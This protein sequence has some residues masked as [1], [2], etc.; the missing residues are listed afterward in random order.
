M[1]LRPEQHLPYFEKLPSANN[2]TPSTPQRCHAKKSLRAMSRRP[3][4]QSRRQK[5][6]LGGKGALQVQLLDLEPA[7][8]GKEA[9]TTD[10]S[11]AE[12]GFLCQGK[13]VSLGLYRVLTGVR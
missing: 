5:G 10:L 13:R 9:E 3:N 6:R 1:T 2:S 11:W 7:A 12:I 8:A 4:Q